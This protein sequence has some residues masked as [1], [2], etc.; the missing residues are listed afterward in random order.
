MEAYIIPLA[1]FLIGLAI[2][3]LSMIKPMFELKRENDL[4]KRHLANRK[5]GRI[6]IKGD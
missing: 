6:I 3:K 2:G 5:R 1:F 4:M